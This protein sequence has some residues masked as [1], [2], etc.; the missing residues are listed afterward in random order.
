MDDAALNLA[1]KNTFL[2][3]GQGKLTLASTA[4]ANESHGRRLFFTGFH[5]DGTPFAVESAPFTGSP[6]ERAATMALDILTTH[7]GVP[8]MPAPAA[9]KG[10]AAT[11]RE[12]LKSATDRAATIG[13]QATDSVKNLHAVLDT[14][15]QVVKDVD[16]AS[17]DIQSALGLSTNGGPGI[18]LGS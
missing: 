3:T 12:Q 18:P 16:S 9:L 11:P 6:L 7:T 14:A 5:A 2:E 1:I 13:A 10:L 8:F 17:A 4:L 15:D